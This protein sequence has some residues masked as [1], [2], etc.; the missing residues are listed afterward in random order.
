MIVFNTKKSYLNCFYDF[1]VSPCSYDFFS[2]LVNAEMCRKR[3]Q[4]SNINL[5][6]VKGPNNGFRHDPRRTDEQNLE[7]YLNVILPGLHFLP[8]VAKYSIYDREDLIGAI[9]DAHSTFPRGYSV[10]KPTFDYLNHER[11]VGQLRGDQSV[12]FE[13]QG[14][15]KKIVMQKL[16]GNNVVRFATLTTR[17]IERDD[18]GKTRQPKRKIWERIFE[19]LREKGI[20]PIVVRD[21][22]CAFGNESL[23]DGVLE[24]PEASLNPQVRLALYEQ[25]EIN[26]TKNNGPGFLQLFAHNRAVYFNTIDEGVI[27]LS[28]N[29]FE[30][31]YGM[32][33]KEKAQYPMT[34]NN[35]IF[36]WGDECLDRALT[37]LEKLSSISK[38]C[39]TLNKYAG[40]KTEE[41]SKKIAFNKVLNNMNFV[42]LPED[43]QLLQ[44]IDFT[45]AS[46]EAVPKLEFISQLEGRSLRKGVVSEIISLSEKLQISI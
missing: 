12:K 45:D 1:A 40:P 30:K 7:F 46:G 41:F 8:T 42:V 36:R 29:W 23:F 39:S 38:S 35:V 11:I 27:S 25:S 32:S 13:S 26:Y 2:F 16:R 28:S 3:R 5:I 33:V 19:A 20:T 44:R 43:L 24:F 34:T 22:A 17:E 37:G 6:F 10:Q 14:F 18:V 4:F 31:G 9:P 21:T 15:A